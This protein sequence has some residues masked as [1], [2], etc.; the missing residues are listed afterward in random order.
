[1]GKIISIPV[2]V[3]NAAGETGAM[4]EV[5]SLAI[6]TQAS[7]QQ[8]DIN[9]I[10]GHVFASG[11][12]TNKQNLLLQGALDKPLNAGEVIHIIRNGEVIGNATVDGSDSAN[13]TWSFEQSEL[14]EGNYSYQTQII[15]AA[16]NKGALSEAFVVTVDTQA[17][18]SLLSVD[19]KNSN[20]GTFSQTQLD[21]SIV[22]AVGISADAV[23]GDMIEVDVNGDGNADAIHVITQADI[24]QVIDISVAGDLFHITDSSV[25][26]SIKVVDKAGNESTAITNQNELMNLYEVELAVD[27]LL[28]I[29]HKGKTIIS[30]DLETKVAKN[31][32]PEELQKVYTSAPKGQ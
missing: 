8:A 10:D 22:I 2:Q 18:D 21:E 31:A 14:I 17:P 16:H 13:I 27:T 9:A 28:L 26:A 15:D 4:S 20:H 25:S 1:M 7:I 12:S 19:I 11:G 32:A 3:A 23:A 24:G 5:Y 6:D 29:E 30:F